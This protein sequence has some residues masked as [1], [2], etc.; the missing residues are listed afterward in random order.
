MIAIY[1]RLSLADKDGIEEAEESN[2]IINQRKLLR[3]YVR[4]QSDLSLLDV[5]EFVDDGF[6]GTNFDRP[7]FQNMLDQIRKHRIDTVIVKDFSRFGRDYIE[8]GNYLERVFP[9]MG[10]RFI[11]V[12]ENYDSNI[13]QT[14]TDRDL[15]INVRNIM[16]SYYSRELS[17]KVR[18]SVNAKRA[19]GEYVYKACPY[20]YDIDPN[21]RGQVVIDPVAGKVV[22]RIFDLAL[23]GASTSEIAKM[24]TEDKVP[25]RGQYFRQ[26]GR[27]G[28]GINSEELGIWNPGMISSII[29]NPVYKGTYVLQVRKPAHFASRRMI[30][31]PKE[32]RKYID[33]HHEGIV[34]TEEF[35]LAQDAVRRTDRG[36]CEVQT[37]PLKGK[38]FCGNCGYKMRVSST[39]KGGDFFYCNL[40]KYSTF[41]IGCFSGRILFTTLH[42]IVFN[43][44]KLWISTLHTVEYQLTEDEKSMLQKK[45]T[46][47]ERLEMKQS[48]LKK[49]QAEKLHLYESYS[50]AVITE[51]VFRQQKDRWAEKAND[52]KKEVDRLQK[53]VQNLRSRKLDD[54]FLELLHK[55]A[56]LE[57]QEELTCQMTD[58]FLD[59]VKVYDEAHIEIRWKFQDLISTIMEGQ[60]S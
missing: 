13:Y 5:E 12:T 45:Q 28:F 19:R 44:L 7:A 6:S 46:L 24:L 33:G 35:E 53:Q 10:V 30:R 55:T 23:Q 60:G 29:R 40:P 16:N 21:D 31:I 1:M 52:L 17:Y 50:D 8:V 32:E 58:A 15:E 34:T 43:A 56:I 48:E 2:S 20:G 3:E 39:K 36:K 37:Y 11:A 27:K 14:G 22:R 18:S 9:F 38:V 49:V 42:E 57:G 59:Q 26:K 51:E 25:T 4:S 54:D 47:E 41:E